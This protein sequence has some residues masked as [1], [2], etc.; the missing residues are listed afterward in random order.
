MYVKVNQDGTIQYPYTI[1]MFRNDADG[2]TF[3]P[4]IGNSILA[5]YDVYPVYVTNAPYQYTK[6]YVSAG[7]TNIDGRWTTQWSEEDATD[8]QI[9]ERTAEKLREVRRERN[10]LLLASDWTQLPDSPLDNVARNIWADYRQTLRDITEG[11]P[12]EV[13][14]P[15]APTS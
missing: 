1:E 2:I 11:S 5:E 3:P 7:V 8:E 15:D 12:F 14:F 10:A 9:A 4:E 13:V 6:N